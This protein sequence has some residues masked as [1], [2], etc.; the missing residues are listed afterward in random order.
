M[1][2]MLIL[3]NHSS[4]FSSLNIL[5]IKNHF[6][7]SICKQIINLNKKLKIRKVNYKEIN[8]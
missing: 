8:T 5:N 1:Y 7:D 4:D 2:K 3:L 6:I